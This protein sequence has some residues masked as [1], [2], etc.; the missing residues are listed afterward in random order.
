MQL[1]VAVV[2]D[3]RLRGFGVM[4]WHVKPEGGLTVRDTDPVNPFSG[5]STIV[6]DEVTPARAGGASV[7][8]TRKSVKVNFAVVACDRE[9]IV[10]VTVTVTVCAVVELHASE[11]VAGEGGR[12]TSLTLQVRL[13]G[14]S[15]T[16]MVPVSPLSPVT[17]MV[18]VA[19]WLMST[20]EGWLAVIVKSVNVKVAVAMRVSE[21][22][23]PVIVTM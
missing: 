10:P 15:E 22:L 1:S 4:V 11:V 18:E 17:V 2:D 14:M 12:I 9:P 7:A 13:P 16:V 21:P 5:E 19:V 23:V 6:E 20:V 8:I 3:G